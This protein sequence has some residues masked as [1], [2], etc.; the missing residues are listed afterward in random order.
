MTCHTCK[1]PDSILA[2][3]KDTRL[4]F[5]QCEVLRCEK[6]RHVT[7]TRHGRRVAAS[8]VWPASTLVSRPSRASDP[9]FATSRRRR[10]NVKRCQNMYVHGVCLRRTAKDNRNEPT[11]PTISEARIS[12]EEL[13]CL[14]FAN[15]STI[16][17]WRLQ[18]TLRRHVRHA[19]TI[20]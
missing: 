4:F 13:H 1:S 15:G 6:C 20:I 19:G 5:L 10:N 8:A 3:D 17:R 7:H 14:R 11:L 12:N 9:S 2:K 16:E 18:L